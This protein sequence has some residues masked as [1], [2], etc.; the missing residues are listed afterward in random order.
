MIYLY[1][2]YLINAAAARQT[3]I[4]AYMSLTCQ[5]VAACRASGSLGAGFS[6]KYH[7]SPLSILGHCGIKSNQS[8]VVSL[9]ITLHPQVLHFTQVEINT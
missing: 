3:A 4:T 7:V 5:F 2:Q 1:I 8:N 9:C 6:E